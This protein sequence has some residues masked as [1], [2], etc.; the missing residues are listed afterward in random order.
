MDNNGAV[1]LKGRVACEIANHELVLTELVFDNV[2]TPLQPCE[3]VALLSCVVFQQ[4]IDMSEVTLPK[5]LQ[6]VS[7]LFLNFNNL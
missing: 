5:P 7:K 3:I 2:F 1:Q 4:R 6:D